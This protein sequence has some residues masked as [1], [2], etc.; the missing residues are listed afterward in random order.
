MENISEE[1]LVQELLNYIRDNYDYELGE[2]FGN[3][4]QFTLKN[5]NVIVIN[6]DVEVYKESEE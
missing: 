5:G 4:M 2:I 3:E 1:E 6:V